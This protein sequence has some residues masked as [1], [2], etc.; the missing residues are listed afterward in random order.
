MKRLAALLVLGGILVFTVNSVQARPEWAQIYKAN[1]V[2]GC[3]WCEIEIEE[4]VWE[5]INECVTATGVPTKDV[6]LIDPNPAPIPLDS[7]K[8]GDHCYCEM[9]CGVDG[10]TSTN[11]YLNCCACHWNPA[12]Q[13]PGN[14]PEEN[15]KK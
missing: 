4:G 10:A 2:I 9:C 14:C 8:E 7:C 3:E 12:L 6:F 15:P 1:P 13:G 11:Y 5:E